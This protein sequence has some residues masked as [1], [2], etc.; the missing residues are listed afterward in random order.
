MDDY[1]DNLINLKKRKKKKRLSFL[2]REN[3]F[4]KCQRHKT[5][6]ARKPNIF[7][8]NK[9]L[10]EKSININY[11]LINISPTNHLSHIKHNSIDEE[12]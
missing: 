12:K 3:I 4:N 5:V 10:D 11:K 9:K 6:K 2:T 8:L 1:F 7:N